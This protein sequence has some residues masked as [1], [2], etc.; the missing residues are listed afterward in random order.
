M[1]E[2]VIITDLGISGSSLSLA[3]VLTDEAALSTEDVEASGGCD[4]V[5]S[6]CPPEL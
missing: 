6:S 2:A 5:T 3:P 4:L 1:P